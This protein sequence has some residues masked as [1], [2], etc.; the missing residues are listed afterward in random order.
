MK[1]FENKV[2]VVT[3]GS[4]GIG[5]ATALAFAEKGAKVAIASI[6]VAEGEETVQLIRETG[7]EAIFVYTDVTKAAE[8]ENFIDQTMAVFGRLDYAFNNAGVTTRMDYVYSYSEEEWDRVININLK[9]VWLS[10]KYEIPQM[11]KQGGGAIVNNV[12]I[13]GV[14]SYGGKAIYT[15]SKHGLIGL[16]KSAAFD[17][18]PQG[19]R[20]N[21]V[22]PGAIETSMLEE[23]FRNNPQ[24]TREQLVAMYPIG[25]IG[26]PID[27]AEAVVWL[28]SDAAAF[29]T[30][31]NLVVDGGLH[32]A[33]I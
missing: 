6:Q 32:S 30:G 33:I 19:I 21:A 17:C 31:H 13:A 15:A 22:S 23:T 1:E 24:F 14:I 5:R 3:G 2:A 10:M 16:T 11:L 9:G 7:G 28:C 8:V 26:Q 29:V 4:S 25:R 27:V 18:A 12:S 20:I